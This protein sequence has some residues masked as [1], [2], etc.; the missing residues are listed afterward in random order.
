MEGQEEAICDHS[1]LIVSAGIRM[2]FHVVSFVQQKVYKDASTSCILWCFVNV[3]RREQKWLRRQVTNAVFSIWRNYTGFAVQETGN[4]TFELCS[5]NLH[6]PSPELCRTCRRLI[7]SNQLKS[8]S[9]KLSALSCGRA[10]TLQHTDLTM[11]CL[12]E[13]TMSTTY[14]T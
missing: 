3:D 1:C 11:L 6:G 13:V 12:A 7:E 2:L 5:L 8:N 14:F 9:N 4:E 10:N